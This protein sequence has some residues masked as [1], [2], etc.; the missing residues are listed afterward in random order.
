MLSQNP[1]IRGFNPD[2][3]ICRVE[4]DYY[5]VTS[6]FEYFPGIPVYHS[7]DLVNWRQIGN[8]IERD[9]QLP[10]ETA[11][12][13][14]GMWAPTIRYYDSVFFVTATFQGYGNFIIH[15]ADPATGWFDPVK[16]DM[17]GIDPSLL[18]DESKAYYC[19]NQRGEDGLEA[20]SLSE[21]D[22]FTGAL[23]SPA[24]VI[25]HGMSDDR[26]QYLEAPHV[27]HIGEWYYLLAAE[28]GTRFNHMITAAR[29]R[30]VWGPYISCDHLI[31]TNRYTKNT[32]VAGSGHGD[33]VEDQNGNW[34]IVHLATR[35]DEDWY[36]H[37]GR[38]T[39]LLPVTWENGWPVIGNGASHLVCEG[40]LWASQNLEASWQADFSFRQPQWL[41]LRKPRWDHYNF[42]GDKLLLTPSPDQLSD[43]LGRPTFLTLRQMDMDCTVETEMDFDPMHDGSEAGLTIFV[44]DY[45]YYTFC[46]RRE[47]GGN[48]LSVYR[49]GGAFQPLSIPAK[50]GPVRLKIS[51][52]KKG[53]SLSCAFS[54]EA[55]RTLA[56]VPPLTKD[57]A[58]KG[59]TGTLIGLY[60]QCRHSNEKKAKVLSFSQNPILKR[61]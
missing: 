49:Q 3:S 8:C 60:A 30:S 48:T 38:E 10:Y 23:L 13:G 33:L 55:F 16:V 39:F 40:P 22:P 54:N 4:K 61:L 20:I 18:F 9:D 32:G 11:A 35:P 52:V 6:S 17:S 14:Q 45:G 28:G 25:W 15:S 5:L 43:P 36:S 53:H 26:P 51:A 42:Q 57:D 21:I 50:D 24:R 44:A 56:S 37:L 27:Y 19:T 46:K 31:L 58:G 47:N 41:F 7:T 2:P 59:F 12:A 34:W 29:S 1:I